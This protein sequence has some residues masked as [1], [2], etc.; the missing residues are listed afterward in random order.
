MKVLSNSDQ[1]D[2]KE[3]HEFVYNH[4]NG[5][6]FQTPEMFEIYR[7]T[8]NYEPIFLAVIDEEIKIKATLL[9]VIQKDY[10]GLL[11]RLTARS[12][13]NGGPCIENDNPAILEIILKEYIK[14]IKTLVI[15]SQFRNFWD[16][17]KVKDIFHKNGILF[18]EHLNIIV[19]LKKSELELWKEVQNKRK[20]EIRKAV[21]EGT[22]FSVRDSLKDLSICYRILVLVYKRA[23]LPIPSYAFFKNIFQ[24]ST[25]NFGL[26]MFCAINQ[27]KIVGCMIA[28]VYKDIIYDF[29][30]GAE[31]QYYNKHP[32]D[33]IPWE[34]FKW[35]QIHKYTKF[36]F[37][38]AGKPGIKYG[39]RDYKQK[40]GGA[41]INF[42]RFQ[43]I[44]Q[45]L[46]Y[47]FAIRSLKVW[48]LFS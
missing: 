43:I 35:G 24:Y 36:D 38:G 19:D 34:V 28:L 11:G 23:K 8:K 30:A 1:I 2:K 31:P 39:V 33:L 14:L 17:S 26:K 13:I 37:G 45:P 41:F 32:N 15:Y 29:F 6:I 10:S 48:R 16:W 40:F 44:H 18:E 4:P 3:W 46:F 25:N 21:K 47:S 42:G 5:N 27:D 20:N 7:N 22:S 9:A 12:I